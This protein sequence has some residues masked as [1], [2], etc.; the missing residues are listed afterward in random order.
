MFE[1]RFREGSGS[2]PRGAL[3]QSDVVS[4]FRGFW[5]RQ[6]Y[7][8]GSYIV[9][10]IAG[11]A[12]TVYVKQRL[13]ENVME[14]SDLLRRYYEYEKAREIERLFL[15][16]YIVAHE[17]LDNILAGNEEAISRQAEQWRSYSDLIALRL[18]EMNPHW[19][20]TELR[21]I[22]DEQFTVI[23]DEMNYH[24]SENAEQIPYDRL[25]NFARKA[26]DYMARGFINQFSITL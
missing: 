24:M 23:W 5:E 2:G 25:D 26:A 16:R 10:L 11:T 20:I 3:T 19:N 1:G 21:E 4:A 12:N 22:L 9:N 6:A 14:L 17:L 18:S 7:W 13:V 8:T 15:D